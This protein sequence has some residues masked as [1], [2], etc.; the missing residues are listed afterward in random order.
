MKNIFL[1]M[2]VVFAMVANAQQT[3]TSTDEKRPL[4]FTEEWNYSE[5]SGEKADW[6]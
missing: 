5:T 4:A 6:M 1:L 2:A 3:D